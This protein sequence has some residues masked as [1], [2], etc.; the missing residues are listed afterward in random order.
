[1]AFWAHG[2]TTGNSPGGGIVSFSG[3]TTPPRQPERGETR[4]TKSKEG[5]VH[6]AAAMRKAWMTIAFAGG[7]LGALAGAAHAQ[8]QDQKPGAVEG[9]VINQLTGE[10]LRRAEVRLVPA[11]VMGGFGRG[12]GAQAG[13]RPDVAAIL[14]GGGPGAGGMGQGGRGGGAGILMA[15]AGAGGLAVLT[16]DEGKFRFDS[17]PPGDYRVVSSRTG[18]IAARRSGAATISVG[19]GARVSNVT[20]GLL[21]QAVLAGRVVDE[22]GEPVQGA[23]IQVMNRRTQRGV[24][25]WVGMRG[26]ATNDLGEF[27]IAGVQ[28]GKVILQVTP[29]GMRRGAPPVSGQAQAQG[30]ARGYVT[31]FYPGV[32]DPSQALTLDVKPGM[33]QSNLD[34]R[35]RRTEVYRITGRVLD[36]SGDVL[37]RFMVNATRLDQA[38]GAGPAGF[39]GGARRDGSFVIE[40]LPPGDYN[41]T[42]RKLG[43]GPQNTAVGSARVGV[44]SS[45]IEGLVVQVSEGFTVTGKVEV[46]GQAAAPVQV[47]SLR[48]NLLPAEAGMMLMGMRPGQPGED[49]SFTLQGVAP[50]KYRIPAATAQGVYLAQVLVGGQD[51]FGKDLDLTG[52]APGPVRMIYR[53]DVAAISGTVEV[54]DSKPLT[55]PVAVI[56]PADPE[57]R[58]AITPRQANVDDAGAFRFDGLRPGEY[59]LWVFDDADLNEMNDED[60]LLTVQEKAVRVRAEPGQSAAAKTR[61][62]AWPLEY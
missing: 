26:N 28:P 57:L 7:L 35:L 4:Q 33:E 46:V 48:V 2:I 11:Q 16:D 59:L 23:Q 5:C 14:S 12:M 45:D 50:G 51:Y 21:P 39:A 17:V 61:L 18:F 19:P 53:T 10:P 62:T 27:R 42:V 1:M 44:G 41:V 54:S 38:G 32:L 13:G 52:G 47:Q 3:R 15:A 9:S 37:Q 6:G 24:R 8:A 40:N 49:G 56:V 31:M 60:F 25:N 22:E 36:V 58:A 55:P 30:P 43:S 20:H 34:I 29:P